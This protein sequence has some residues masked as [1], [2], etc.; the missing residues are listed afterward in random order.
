MIQE[1]LKTPI[2]SFIHSF[3][4]NHIY[5]Q[6]NWI[7][8]TDFCQTA[9]KAVGFGQGWSYTSLWDS[10]IPF[11]SHQL[12]HL[13][14]QRAVRVLKLSVSLLYQF[15][16]SREHNFFFF[17][18]ILLCHSLIQSIPLVCFLY[19]TPVTRCSSCLDI[20]SSP[21]IYCPST[22][23]WPTLLSHTPDFPESLLFK[24][25]PK[26]HSWH[27]Q[28]RIFPP[29]IEFLNFIPKMRTQSFL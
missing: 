27:F 25:S 8:S 28:I 15:S 5:P 26:L 19:V 22:T 3:M 24:V 12:K 16:F 29:L 2:N 17:A 14:V 13:K 20:F 1:P 6:D 11:G 4:S 18:T 23:S 7:M 21:P 9:G 10:H